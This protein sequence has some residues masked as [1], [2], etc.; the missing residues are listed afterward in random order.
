M[1]TFR[2]ALSVFF[3][4][5]LAPALA[6]A[7][8]EPSEAPVVVEPTSSIPSSPMP[9]DQQAENR[10]L[11]DDEKKDSGR[12][13]EIVWANAEAGFSYVNMQSL[14][15]SNFQIQKSS[16]DGAM[17]GLGA[18]LRFLIFTVGVRARLDELSAFNLWE[19]NG[20]L[21]FHIPAG[22]WDPYLSLHG[23]YTFVGTLNSSALGASITASPSDISI[24]GADAGLSLGVDYYIIPYLSIGL[25]LTGEALFLSRPPAS[26][27]ADFSLLSA[28]M[29]NVIK[30]QPIYQA[31]GD[32]AGLGAAGSLHVGLHL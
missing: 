29:Q 9:Q 6:R 17:F 16:S 4:A 32:A 7:Q 24:H 8:D 22:K 5:T 18:G 12:V 31:S 2:I 10:K 1:T 20:E 26:L 14:S 25:D 13:F 30:S 27:P 3:C 19:T 21:G 28:S 23:G 15:S 11:A